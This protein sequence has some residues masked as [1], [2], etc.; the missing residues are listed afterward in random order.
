MKKWKTNKTIVVL[1]SSIVLMLM[2]FYFACQYTLAWLYK[3]GNTTNSGTTNSAKTEVKSSSTTTEFTTGL[4][5]TPK[6]VTA[7]NSITNNGTTNVLL[8]VFYSI[9]VNESTKEIATTRYF[10]NVTLNS[11]FLASDENIENTY[12]G[13]FYYNTTLAPNASVSLVS[14]V[15]PTAEGANKTMKIKMT[16]EMVDYTG[17]VYRLGYK[18][19][20]TNTPAGW[21]ANNYTLTKVKSSTVAPKLGVKWNQVSKI[22]LTAKTTAKNS[23]IFFCT[24]NSAWI[25]INGNSWKFTSLTGTADK[26]VDQFTSGTM[27]KV[28]FTISSTLNTEISMVWDAIW[29]QEIEFGQIKMYDTDG[30]VLLNMVP[31]KYGKFYDKKSETTMDMYNWASGTASTTSNIY[32]V[33]KHCET[34]DGGF[35]SY[36]VGTYTGLTNQANATMEIVDTDAFEGTKCLKLSGSYGVSGRIYNHVSVLKGKKY[37][38][39][40]AMKS[41]MPAGTTM[42]NGMKGS[43]RF[44]L[45]GGSY[46]WSG[47]TNDDSSIYSGSGDWEILTLETDVLTSDTTIFCFL[48]VPSGAGINFYIDA[49]HVMEVQ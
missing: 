37:R 20:W 26:T 3:N 49:W 15:T 14:S 31:S 7:N 22:E 18:D 12:S 27:T 17:G 40:I 44:E 8:R 34:I 9:Y 2:L 43:L 16:V 21:F 32:Y 25:G 23:N 19:P 6:S 39:S 47:I 11:G 33:S 35:E 30:N 48:C 28:T 5:G 1:I 29:A 42:L 10:S 45:N 24:Y 36:G 38:F 46:N 41:N 4:N 13:V